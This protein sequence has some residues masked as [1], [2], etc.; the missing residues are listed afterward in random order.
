MARQLSQLAA[1]LWPLFVPRLDRWARDLALSGG[2]G[3]TLQAEFT[4]TIADSQAPQ[5]LMRDGS[6]SLTGD[7]AVD[8]G[9]TIDGVDISAH[10]ANASAHHA[11]V[12]AGNGISL[13]GQQVAVG[14][15]TDPGLEF[16]SGLLRVRAGDG[17]QRTSGGVA[18]DSTV[19]RTTRQVATGSGLTGGG[20]LS[21]NRTLDLADSVAGNGLTISAKVLSVGAG[22]MISVGA[23]TVGISPGA[24]FQFIGTGSSTT[25]GWRNVSEL[26]GAGLSHSAG[27]L[28]LTTPGTLTGDTTNASSG[29]HTHAIT[30]GAASTLS[31][32]STNTTG[33]GSALARADHT[34]AITASFNPGA[35]AALLRTADSGSL[36]LVTLASNVTFASGFTGA[37][38]RVDYGVAEAGKATAEFDNLTVRGTFR[39]YELLVQQLR[40]T[41]GSVLVSSACKA[42]TVVVFARRIQV[43]SDQLTFNSEPA[44]FSTAVYELTTNDTGTAS[45]D[46]HRLYHGFLVG[47]V[48]RSQRLELNSSGNFVEVR[49][50]DL[51]VTEVDTLYRFV[52][53]LNGGQDPVVGDEFARLG[54]FSN[55]NRQGAVYIT[56]DDT[57]AP[58]ID[59]VDGIRTHADWNSAANRRV[60]LGRLSGITDADFGGNL[61]GYGLYA[62]N[63]YLKGRMIVSGGNVVTTGNAAADVNANATTIDGGKI[64]A[65]TITATQIAAG[66]ITATQIASGTITA[67]QIASGTITAT[68]IAAGTITADRLNVSQ[69]SA[70]AANMGALTVD[71]VLTLGASGGLYQGT[72]TFASP[73]T[74]LKIW[75]DGGVGRIAGFNSGTMQWY[76]NTSGQMVAGAG[77][78]SLDSSGVKII[79]SNLEYPSAP[80]LNAYRFVA[81]NSNEIGGLM[82]NYQASP[83]SDDISSVAL[84]SYGGTDVRPS[85]F[86][87]ARRLD[88]VGDG[89]VATAMIQARKDRSGGT[90]GW[91]Y[92][93]MESGDGH[94]SPYQSVWG[95]MQFFGSEHHFHPARFDNDIETYKTLTVNAT[96]TPDFASGK[97]K[98]YVRNNKLI[99]QWRDGSTTRYKYLDLTG[100]GVTWEHSTTAP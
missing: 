16:A 41:N 87:E 40:A 42:Q 69:L 95:H 13:T 39:V 80:Q 97:A 86:V 59:I 17:I 15:A 35:A 99:V 77:A 76:T 18:V 47:D 2:A 81:P 1:E 61:D 10:A 48:V 44:V 51:Y 100:T 30:T 53:A 98:I 94:A 72:G 34:H 37:G 70:I 54:S 8:A 75:R 65:G 31:V 20:D 56:A 22:T 7:L 66:T 46:N 9:V 26:A 58:F 67:T 4:G 90:N 85:V 62:D 73:T 29:S 28:S 83:I 63:V 91:A 84:L 43:N 92:I 33:S 52:G 60:R 74:G 27:V 12:T 19:V 68:Q 71:D 82:A 23:T 6:R 89:V 3:G 57:A 36:Q 32:S 64:T 38:Y 11:P 78:V 45:G 93:R 24:N 55:T 49:R 50:T 21:A 25:A 5:F 79:A 88:G 14:L 96:S